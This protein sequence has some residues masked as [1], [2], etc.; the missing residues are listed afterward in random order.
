MI[1]RSFHGIVV[2][3][4]ACLLVIG[5]KRGADESS[6]AGVVQAPR[7]TPMAALY[8]RCK[9][10][11]VNIST[12]T[13]EDN[14]EGAAYQTAWGA[15][16]ILHPAGYVITAEHVIRPNGRTMVFL[17]SGEYRDCRVLVRY[18]PLDIALLKLEG[19]QP[20]DTLEVGR[21]NDL[22]VGEPAA[23]I[24]NPTGLWNTLSVG[25]ISGLDRHSA[26]AAS[27]MYGL[28]QTDASVSH[29]S[30]GGPLLN[31]FGEVIG[32]ID[33][34]KSEAENIGFAIPIDQLR[35][36]F[37]A[38]VS[39]EKRSG[40]V[41]GMSI[42][43]LAPEARVVGVAEGSPA[44][45]VGIRPGDVIKRVGQMEVRHGLDYYLALID[46]SAGQEVPIALSRNGRSLEVLVRL[47]EMALRPAVTTPVL[48]SGLK[49]EGFIGN[50]DRLPDFEKL[51]PVKVGNVA[52]VV[53]PELNE[54][55]PG[56]AVRFTG[57]LDVPADGLYTFF[58][59]SDDGSRLYISD[60]LLIDNDFVH[61]PQV[62]NG[63]IRLQAGKHPIT[64]LYFDNRGKKSLTLEIEGPGLEKQSVP[65]TMLF[66]DAAPEAPEVIDVPVN[67][68]AELVE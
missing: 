31:A 46:C 23:T 35:T 29:G 22:M 9:Q 14:D 43:T 57:Y 18:A 68:P 28:I 24:G 66:T 42:D 65:E 21:S 4:A 3:A 51:S 27:Y 11:V 60:E 30:S 7:R 16:W 56:V 64:V 33:G 38:M 44:A 59:T 34:V 25:V 15:G 17:H 55:T 41:L 36:H 45:A 54:A 47:A 12:I 62:R 58:L 40:F 53:L 20:F 32:V 50:W 6:R 49:Y 13:Q 61:M 67:G 2:C 8:D 39:P 19:T 63:L 37:P 5:C 26:A 48:N 1:F 10:A 52:T